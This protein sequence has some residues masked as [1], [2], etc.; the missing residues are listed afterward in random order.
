MLL[1]TLINPESLLFFGNQF[2]LVHCSS[3]WRY[4]ATFCIMNICFILFKIL[5]IM[6]LLKKFIKFPPNLGF[7]GR[8]MDGYSCGTCSDCSDVVVL[9]Q[10]F[11]LLSSKQQGGPSLSLQVFDPIYIFTLYVYI[12]KKQYR[13][14]HLLDLFFREFTLK[15]SFWFALTS[16]TP[17][18]IIKRI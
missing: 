14:S 7:E 17:Q 10:I 16:F 8:G 4:E 18:G 12:Q 5:E 11:S 1:L 9:G 3:S 15:E 2:A 6:Q 13:L